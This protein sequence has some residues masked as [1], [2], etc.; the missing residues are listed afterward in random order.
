MG[1]SLER[2]KASRSSLRM[3]LTAALYISVYARTSLWPGENF[4]SKSWSSSWRM[5]SC[6]WN[7]DSV[8]CLGME[9]FWSPLSASPMG[10]GWRLGSINP[11]PGCPFPQL[12][13]MNPGMVL[14]MG[15]VSLLTH[16]PADGW[17]IDARWV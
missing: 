9:A 6:W 14:L 13:V 8:T 3:S 1:V 4:W 5:L 7:S 17:V 16:P 11:A 12:M 2:S 15:S 10:R